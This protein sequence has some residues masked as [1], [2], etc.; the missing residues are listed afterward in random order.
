[1]H[2]NEVVDLQK[3]R[4]TDTAPDVT[5]E[6]GDRSL[7]A[8]TTLLVGQYII[9]GYLNCGGFGITY[10]ARDSLGRKVVLKECFPAEMVYRNGKAMAC[11]SPKYLKEL[12]SIVRNFVTEA[13][14]L[15]NVRHDNIVHVHQIFEE[16]GTAYLAMDFVDGPDLLDMLDSS[17][18][19]EPRQV[20]TVTRQILDAVLYLHRIGMLHRDISPDNILMQQDGTPVL[21]DF[22]AARHISPDDTS[23]A[24]MKF[25]KDGYS[26]L[27]F[28]LAGSPQGRFSD[29]YALAATLYHVITGAAPVDAQTRDAAR[30]ASKPDPYVPLTGQVSGYPIR[31]LK[32]IDAALILAPEDRLQTAQNWLDLIGRKTTIPG[33]GFFTPVTAVLESLPSFDNSPHGPANGKAKD[34]RKL[35]LAAGAATVALVVGGIT[36]A[37]QLERPTDI[38]ATAVLVEPTPRELRT[39]ASLPEPTPLDSVWPDGFAALRNAP[40]LDPVIGT[41]NGAQPSLASGDTTL[42]ATRSVDIAATPTALA[43][44]APTL[45]I[46]PV[47]AADTTLALHLP[48]RDPATRPGALAPTARKTAFGTTQ[49][50][51]GNQLQTSTSR[52]DMTSIAPVSL[53]G[54][55]A[56]LPEAPTAPRLVLDTAAPRYT[57]LETIEPTSLS[58]SYWDVELPFSSRP[59][60]IG[61]GNALVI[62][63]V[64]PNADLALFG[65]WITEGLILVGLNGAPLRDDLSLKSQIL[66]GLTMDEDGYARASLYYRAPRED[67][68]DQAAITLPIIRRTTLADGTRLETRKLGQSWITSVNAL[69]TATTD[70]QVGDIIVGSGTNAVRFTDRQSV[71]TTMTALVQG[72]FTSARFSVLRKGQRE[73]AS[74]RYDH[75]SSRTAESR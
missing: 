23:T 45:S 43:P 68:L 11:R 28:Y 12:K 69:G 5:K 15:A 61:D 17:K 2:S 52:V 19:L 21:I 73:N 57:P 26:P 32:A 48:V 34:R 35:A 65:D 1:M 36:V 18:T 29:L 56:S 22:G 46:S 13:H 25:V 59:Q 66:D 71:E 64:D 24:A 74:W 55:V 33:A 75:A 49:G 44:P 10:T 62:T 20:E 38:A 47:A 72:D 50:P 7:P 53:V 27:E 37:T 6:D 39:L 40:T 42:A 3:F 4:S 60:R 16:N 14:S 41:K 9:D 31:F 63:E 70:L 30:A 67:V 58:G 54:E 8:G 51:D